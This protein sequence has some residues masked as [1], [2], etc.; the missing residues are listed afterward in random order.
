M[1]FD[2]LWGELPLEGSWI[3]SLP[4]ETKDFLTFCSANDGACAAVQTNGN[5]GVKE[6]FN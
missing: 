1:Q 2:D 6:L 3:A 5:T 4:P